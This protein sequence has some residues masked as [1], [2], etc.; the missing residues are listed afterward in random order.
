MICQSI[1]WAYSDT[2]WITHAE[3]TLH[4]DIFIWMQKQYIS[5]AVEW[6]EFNTFATGGACCRID[7]DSLRFRMYRHGTIHRA[8]FKAFWIPTLAANI[9]LGIFHKDIHDEVKPC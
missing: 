1:V 7:D 4:G 5:F 9:H 8:S 2:L 3:V 6:A